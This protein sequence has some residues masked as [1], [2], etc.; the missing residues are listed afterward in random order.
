MIKLTKLE[1]YEDDNGNTIEYDGP[2][3]T[4]N[5]TIE[6]RGKRNRLVVKAPTRINRL[7]VWF[8][9]DDGL[10]EIDENSNTSGAYLR[11]KSRVGEDSKISVG[12]NVTMTGPCY[13]TA[14]EGTSITVGD[15]CMIAVANEIRTHDGHPIFELKTGER[16]NKSSC[17]HV[18]NHVWLGKEAVLLGGSKVGDGSVIG[19][20]SVVTSEIP[21]NCVAVGLPAKVIKRDIAWERPNL[22]I[23]KPHY[24]PGANEITPSPYWNPTAES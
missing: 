9:R 14:A 2:T 15:D 3:L 19:F 24:K 1:R 20:R 8:D 4:E 13:M 11:L 18:G 5:V 17:I 23:T 10:V 12:K 16:A 21:N 22:T 6:F 7:M